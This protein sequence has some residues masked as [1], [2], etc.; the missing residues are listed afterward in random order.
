MGL[1]KLV[2]LIRQCF[3]ELNA[4]PQCAGFHHPRSTCERGLL[5]INA[6]H[7]LARNEIKRQ[8]KYLEACDC[9]CDCETLDDVSLRGG[10]EQGNCAI[11][12]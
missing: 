4:D 12:N 5:T 10:A 1:G 6:L 9:D 7:G 2:Q 3:R 11:G 8:E